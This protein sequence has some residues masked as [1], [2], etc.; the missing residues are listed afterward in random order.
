MYG[1]CGEMSEPG[2]GSIGASVHGWGPLEE[3]GAMP[4]DTLSRP[5]SSVPEALAA[6]HVKGAIR[7]RV[8]RNS[9]HRS[10][11]GA[12]SCRPSVQWPNANTPERRG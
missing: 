3:R 5:A 1:V 6:A 2:N 9:E 11:V 4:L 10:R 8:Y 12:A 7:R